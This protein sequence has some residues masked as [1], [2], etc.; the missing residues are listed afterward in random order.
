MIG[1]LRESYSF[2]LQCYKYIKN[3]NENID[4]IYANTWPLF[5]QYF[6]VQAAR[7][8]NIPLIHFKKKACGINPDAYIWK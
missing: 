2:G 8:F 7:K 4:T 1:R 5:A 6:L 3:N